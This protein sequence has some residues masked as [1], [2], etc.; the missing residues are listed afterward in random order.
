MYRAGA[1]R[2]RKRSR[3]AQQHDDRPLA[4]PCLR[5][6]RRR[7]NFLVGHLQHQPVIHD[8]I[9]RA[10][11]PG[12]RSVRPDREGVA[13]LDAFVTVRGL[14]FRDRV[15]RSRN[16][17]GQRGRAVLRASK[18][19]LGRAVGEHAG[20]LELGTGKRLAVLGHLAQ[21]D[22]DG[23]ILHRHH[24]GPAH[25]VDGHGVT[26]ALRRL[27]VH[28]HRAVVMDAQHHIAQEFVAGRSL[29]FP[30]QISLAVLASQ[31]H[32]VLEQHA[33]IVG[34]ERFLR[35]PIGE[36][37][38]HG[39]LGSRKRI[40]C[41][42]TLDQRNPDQVVLHGNHRRAVDVFCGR[43]QPAA[44]FARHAAGRVGTVEGQRAVVVDRERGRPRQFMPCR[45]RHFGNGVGRT[46]H[47]PG[48]VD[49]NR[50][51]GSAR[52]RFGVGAVV[53]NDLEH[54]AR[55]RLAVAVGLHD[56]RL[57]GRIGHR[58]RNDA[59][60]RNLISRLS[61]AC[62]HAAGSRRH[63]A[64]CRHHEAEGVRRY[65]VSVRRTHL[66]NGVR[67]ARHQQCL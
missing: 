48:G 12:K 54:R 27:V 35:I 64:V 25:L 15:R 47:Q 50:A 62:L 63:A 55:Q 41:G 16:Q 60:I 14:L 28:H 33:R 61:G 56:F 49:F 34:R 26:H 59:V 45:S 19:L 10:R 24:C 65:F 58:Q 3:N 7:R 8:G 6:Q 5:Q 53:G 38:L 17:G 30:N 57:D 37:A 32:V 42:V 36:P 13:F 2:R 51:V 40:A 20:H 9:A 67:L 31:K 21:P 1:R 66:D 11:L 52:K 22:L 39:E 44:L 23:R 18:R 29:R 43:V 4:V 46:R